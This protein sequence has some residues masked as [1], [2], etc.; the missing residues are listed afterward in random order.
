MIMSDILRPVLTGSGD[1]DFKI[2]HTCINSYNPY[3]IPLLL[4]FFRKQQIQIRQVE[5]WKL[6]RFQCVK[7][8]DYLKVFISSDTAGKRYYIPS[9]FQMAGQLKIWEIDGGVWMVDIA[10]Q[11]INIQLLGFFYLSKKASYISHDRLPFMWYSTC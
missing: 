1:I 6:Y 5:L 4:T 2:P 8:D 11:V 3:Y 9:N 10:W 7:K